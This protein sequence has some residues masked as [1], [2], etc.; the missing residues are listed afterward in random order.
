MTDYALWEVILNGDSP[1]PTRY[2][3]GVE[4]PYPPTT[5]EEKLAR[6]NELKAR[7]DGLKVADGN[8]DYESQKIPIEN[9]KE[10]R[11]C[12][13][14][15]HQDHRSRKA[16]RRTVP[17]KDTTLNDFVSQ[18]NGLGFDWSDQTEDGQTNFALIAHTSSS[19]SSSSN[20]DTEVSH[21]L[22]LDKRCI[23]RMRN[24]M[25]LKPDLVFVDKH[26]VNESVASLPGIAKS[27]VETSEIKL[28]NV[29]T[30]IIKDWVSD[31]EDENEIKTKIKQIKPSFAKV[32][33]VNSTEHVKSLRKSVKQEENNRQTKYPR[34]NSQSPRVMRTFNQ[35]TSPKNSD[36]KENFTAKGNPQSTLQDQVIFDSGCFRHMTGN[37]SFLTDYQELDGGFVA[38]GGSPK[39]GKIYEKGKIRSGKLDFEDV[40][41][42]KELK[43]NLF[44][45]SQMYDKKN[46]VLFTETEC[47]VLYP[48][49]KLLDKN[50]VLL[51]VP[52][53]NNMYSFD[54]KHVAPLRDHLGKFEGKA[55]EGFLVKYSINSKAFRSSDDKDVDEVP[56][57][58]DEGIS[59]GSGIDDQEKTYSS[60]QDVNTIGPSINTANTNINTGSLN[61]NINGSNDPN[62]PS[63]E[64]TGIFNDVYNDR[65]VGAE[66]DTNNLELSIVVSPIPTTRV[67][68][69]H[70]KE[71]IIGDLNSA[72]QT[73]RM[74]NFSEENAMASYINKQRRINNKDYHN[75]LFA[76]F[77]SQQ[78]PKKVIQALADPNWIEAMQD[79]LLQFKLQ[80]VW[81]LVDIPNGKRG[82][83]DKTLFIKKEKDG[84]LLVQVYVDDIIFGSIKKFLFDEFE[85][86][87]QK[88][89]QMSCMGELIFFIGLQVKQKDDG[90]F[91][92]QD[93][94][95]A[96]ILKKFDF[97][98]V[99]TAST[100]IETHKAFL[101]DEEA[102]DVN[103][104]LYRSMIR[105]LMC[106]TASR[107][108]IMFVVCASFSDSDYAKAS[109]DI[110]ST[111]RGCQILRKRVLSWQC[112]KQTVVGNSTTEVEYVD[113]A[114]YCGQVLW[115]QNQM[116]DYRFNFM[117][118]KLYIDNES[119]ICIVKNPVFH[120][121]TKHIEIRHHF[122][123]DSY[124]KKLIQV[125]KIHIDHNVA[126]LLTKAF[127]V[128][129]FNFLVASIG[130]LN[131]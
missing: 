112:K 93:K 41:F 106:L 95:V 7:G 22:R 88:R 38:F 70:P 15:K 26:V 113:A 96:D 24:Y 89:F 13:A 3:K 125:I 9:K 46:S 35:R 118:N 10:S 98:L 72:T 117:N 63:L 51:K 54:L 50:Q 85:Q 30:P 31:I 17:V 104:H 100:P 11:E 6:K 21:L 123:R 56:G 126:D 128:S 79:E 65:E 107:P 47:L 120:S 81:A 121:K 80:K 52:R 92:S 108:D 111:T 130:L 23:K 27:K 64:E 59:K 131:L 44:S 12:R 62:R 101:K 36:L 39:G 33:F 97:S 94:Y 91:I 103:V 32:K 122:I 42:V 99:K 68:K 49:F 76:Y 66:A 74:I 124:E 20:S 25:P 58:G 16:P 37:K 60:T 73:R 5:L 55:D 28:K 115:I 77:L 127:D 34:K 40:Y 48:D 83:I 4:T 82:I 1:P 102:Q 67:H 43:F 114:S 57:K 19:S 109:L 116:L 129:R 18:C 84:I 87:M 45:V 86:M 14:S 119:T 69:D 2:V 75:Y 110:K 71:Q 29:S 53:Q 105:S 8:V 61:I 90:I 78:E